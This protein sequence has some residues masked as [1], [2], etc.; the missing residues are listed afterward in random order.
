MD[1]PTI[2]I[3]RALASDAEA[4]KKIFEGQRAVWG[5]LQ[6]PY[7]TTAKWEKWITDSSE[8]V[9]RFVACVEN[10]V[11]GEFGLDTFPTHP[12][13]KHVGEIGMAVHEDWHGKGVG[14]AMMQAAID[15]ADKWLNLSRLEL[16]VYTDN[17]PAIA[18]YKK[19]GFVIEGTM[20]NF[21]FRDGQF[22]D[23]YSMARL[24]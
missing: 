12:R 2:T 9:F 1:K 16:G 22:V 7:P 5:T 17:E 10:E 6:L 11:V 21:A 18:L 19:F 4:I 13:R 14:S 24:K 23:I 8:G 20:K 3:R 15:L